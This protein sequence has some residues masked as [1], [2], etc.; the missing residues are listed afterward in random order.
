MQKPTTG[1]HGRTIAIPAHSG[2]AGKRN[3]MIGSATG[4]RIGVH[5]GVGVEEFDG[6]GGVRGAWTQSASG[7]DISTSSLMLWTSS[8]L[9]WTSLLWPSAANR[10]S[11]EAW[12]HCA[13]TALAAS[14][15]SR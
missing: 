9:L 6:G 1:A 2:Y 14:S 13:A 7:D 15:H 12:E 11:A 3:D 10:A 8:L 5:V 4:M